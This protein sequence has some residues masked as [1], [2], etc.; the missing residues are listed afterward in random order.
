MR[1]VEALIYVTLLTAFLDALLGKW[2]IWSRYQAWASNSG[3]RWAYDL[4]FCDLCKRF[5]LSVIISGVLL[6]IWGYFPGILAVPFLVGGA[7]QILEK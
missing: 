4:S 1:T 6:L 2:G 5:W 7:F 3:L